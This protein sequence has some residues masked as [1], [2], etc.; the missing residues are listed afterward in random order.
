MNKELLSFFSLFTALF[1]GALYYTNNIQG[2]LISALNYLK[3]NYH[4][5]TEFIQDSIDKHT[6]QADNITSLKEKLQKY[7]NNHLVMQQMASEVDDLYKANKSELTTDPKV[8]LVRAISYQKFGDLNR[9]WID[10]RDYNSSKIYGLTYNE[11]VAG[12]VVPQNN[13]PL[14]LLNR[15]IQSS[16]AVYVGKK[17]AP[18]IA[19]GNNAKNL[20]VKFIPAWFKIEEGD[21][22]ITSGLDKIFFKG[23]KVGRVLSVKKSQGYQNAIIEPYYESNDPSYFYMIKRIR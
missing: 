11:M 9:V 12:I 1:V 22:V 19:H 10:A 23:L 4:Y 20:V 21:E 5:T 13:K 7:E 14:G 3:S 18:G 6:F 2:P 15:D 16:Y 8:E 17:R